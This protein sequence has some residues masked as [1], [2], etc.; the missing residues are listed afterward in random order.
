MCGAEQGWEE[1]DDMQQASR[2]PR[3]EKGRRVTVCS[4]Q[5]HATSFSFLGGCVSGR[6]SGWR[7]SAACCFY[8]FY[9][10]LMTWASEKWGQVA[11]LAL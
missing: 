6:G 4:R 11:G 7:C 2:Q 10:N 5:Q 9:F 1:C 3:S 8:L